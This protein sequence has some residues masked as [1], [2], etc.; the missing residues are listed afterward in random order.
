MQ[1]II[2]QQIAK[3]FLA[4]IFLFLTACADSSSQEPIQAPS[5]NGSSNNGSSD[6]SSS[7]SAPIATAQS[8]T[9]DE[10]TAKSITLSA[11]D[12]NNDSLTYRITSQPEKGTLTGNAPN[13]TYTPNA[14]ENGADS[15]T[16]KVNDGTNDSVSDA[17]VS[18]TIT[19]VADLSF[20]ETSVKV[21][22][23]N[24]G[25][26]TLVFILTVDTYEGVASVDYATSD[27]TATANDDYVAQ[28]GTVTFKNGSRSETIS[29]EI[30]SDDTVEPDET[31][32]LTLSNASNLQ[33]STATATGT[34]IDDDLRLNDTGIT[35]AGE[36][37]SG[38]KT[39]NE[40]STTTITGKQDCHYGRDK[41]HNDDTDG[42]AGFS[43]TKLDATGK[44]LTNQAD[45]GHACVKDNVTGLI[46]EV[47]TTS[48]MRSKKTK[49]KWG[50]LTAIGR[51]H[52]RKKGSYYD[53]WNELV[54]YANDTSNA[55]TAGDALCGFRDWRVPNKEELFS[56]AHLGK[57]NPGIDGRY[58]PNTQKGWYWSSSPYAYYTNYARILIFINGRDSISI[59]DGNRYVRLVRGG[60]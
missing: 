28:T 2:Q 21:K 5:N 22:E 30:N 40:C 11:T 6:D 15:F 60:Q 34:I 48:G 41:T 7:D 16:F 32:T 23:G 37:S 56:I 46:W 8:I 59:R 39:G 35:W 18:I 20:S 3:F 33:L 44:A 36:Y 55:N 1:P 50:G 49:Y 31:F 4:L 10:D 53:D 27:N 58:F 29:I 14:N 24:T 13:L 26:T 17:T 54:N 57:N 19:P 47:K 12:S 25:T 9:T 42:M 43:F 51:D 38:N 52:T 45:T